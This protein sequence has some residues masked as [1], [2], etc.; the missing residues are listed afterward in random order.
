M[1]VA[2]FFLTLACLRVPAQNSAE[3]GSLGD[4]ARQTRAQH[5]AD[6][7]KSNKAQ[8]IVDEMEQAQEAADNAP[9][10]FKNYDAGDYRIFVPYPYSLEG[11]D[12]G[13]AVLLGS[14]LGVTNT[15]VMAGT[16]VPMPAN[17]ND[18]DLQNFVNQLARRYSQGTYCSQATKL[19][20]HKVFRCGMN[21]GYLLGHE[22]WGSM[23]F[24]VAS[25]SVIPIVCVS[26]DDLNNCVGYD[27]YGGWQTC[28]KRH[29]SWEEVQ[30]EQK[31]VLTRFQDER[32]TMQVCDQVIYPSVQLKEDIVVHPVN[33][34]ETKAM[35]PVQVAQDTRVPPPLTASSGTQAPSL[36]ELARQSRQAAHGKTQAALDNSEGK[37]LEPPGFQSFAVQYCQNPQACSE[38]KIM[39][40]E[41][42]EVVS[43]INGQHIFK[44]MLN[45]DPV[46]LYAGPADVNNPYRSMTDRDYARIR[47]VANSNGWSREKTDGVSTQELTIDGHPALMTHFRYQRESNTWWVGE[48]ALIQVKAS[49][50]DPGSQFL[51]GCAAPEQRFADAE[52]LCTT[53]VNSLRLQ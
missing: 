26:P 22:V 7:G 18:A 16:P 15:E 36:A 24:V 52:A 51:V 37:G 43:R 4:L 2:I 23:E 28:S 47:D 6:P 45:G 48:R 3:S 17:L 21:K 10:G 35:K 13:G 32:T 20:D 41:K 39:I 19:G 25:N 30:R 49:P 31:A 5:A 12:N 11:R 38:A 46:L 53:L 8:A 33:I 42:A 14:R 27:Q 44:F 50:Y 29:P 9:T 34:A 1:V 40:P